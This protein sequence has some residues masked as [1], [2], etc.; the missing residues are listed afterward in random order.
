MIED[1]YK[2]EIGD[3][4]IDSNSSSDN[5]PKA[6]NHN[7]KVSEDIGEASQKNINSSST[8]LYQIDQFQKSKPDFSHDVEMS[9]HGEIN[10]DYS[11][12]KSTGEQD[13]LFQSNAYQMAELDMFGQQGGI[14][15]TLG[16]QH[17]RGDEMYNTV[18]STVEASNADTD[19]MDPDNQQYRFGT[20]HLLHDF[21]P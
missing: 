12:M 11:G 5:T 10:L 15:L 18:A 19:C 2:E 9:A 7:I 8:E 21:V 20:S 17:M 3:S 4:E 1:M 13:A 14:S 6:V 16:L